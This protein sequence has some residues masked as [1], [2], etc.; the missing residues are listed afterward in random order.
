MATMLN[1]T[2]EGCEVLTNDRALYKEI[3]RTQ[4]AIKA[5]IIRGKDRTASALWKSF[6]LHYENDLKVEV[7]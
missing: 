5:T 4:E 1:L 7:H 6:E 2:K 3:R